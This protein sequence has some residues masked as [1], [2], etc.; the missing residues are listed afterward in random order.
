ME[1]RKILLQLF[2]LLLSTT[3]FSQS[4]GLK[5]TT[6]GNI[7]IGQSSPIEKLDVNGAIKI[8]NTSSTC[9]GANA[10]T[11]R[12]N[13]TCFEGCD[14]TN[15]VGLS[16]DT[17]CGGGG[18]TPTP[19]CATGCECFPNVDGSRP[20]QMT[21]SWSNEFD[22]GGDG[23]SNDGELCFTVGDIQGFSHQYLGLSSNPYQ[24]DIYTNIDYSIYI[25]NYSSGYFLMQAYQSGIY[26]GFVSYNQTSLTNSTICIKREA[27]VV[28]I[29][30]D[31]S[32]MFTFSGTS[33]GNLYYD[34]SFSGTC[35]SGT[36]CV[37]EIENIQVCD[38]ITPSLL[39]NDRDKISKLSK[40]LIEINRA[41][42]MEEFL[43]LENNQVDNFIQK[44]ESVDYEITLSSKV[45]N[46]RLFQNK[47][48]PFVTYTEIEFELPTDF[49]NAKI[50]IKNSIGKN[51]HSIPL[52][53]GRQKGRIKIVTENLSAGMYIYT[54]NIDGKSILSK[55]MIKSSR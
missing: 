51:I 47:P 11:I 19:G 46:P 27:G 30:I 45:K 18:T 2:F 36:N 12:W 4:N 49:N 22:V 48:N 9:N 29:Y 16:N 33:S 6:N 3:V 52:D 41:L 28:S 17:N 55:K 31:G 21:P 8:D 25:A 26:S 34:N 50:D 38:Y 23:F 42:E 7:G 37:F 20:G 13:G 32:S 44:L 43:S 40:K 35:T 10:G 24:N 53:S 5:I 54:L 39:T 15:W 1:L 14:G